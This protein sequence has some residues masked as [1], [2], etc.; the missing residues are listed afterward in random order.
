MEILLILF[1]KEL[2][3]IKEHQ[4]KRTYMSAIHRARFI[5]SWRL[6]SDCTY[7]LPY[8]LRSRSGAGFFCS[9]LWS[10]L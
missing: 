6:L 8:K 10:S 2:D 4:G 7:T 3:K 9:Y 1:F 5:R